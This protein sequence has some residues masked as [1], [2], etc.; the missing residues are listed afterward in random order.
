MRCFILNEKNLDYRYGIE[1]ILNYLNKLDIKRNM[2]L[3]Y[4]NDFYPGVL[5]IKPLGVDFEDT[6]Y[7]KEDFMVWKGFCFNSIGFRVDN[8][9]FNTEKK[10]LEA[11]K[12]NYSV[13][14]N[15]FH[16][17]SYFV[18]PYMEQINLDDLEE[19]EEEEVEAVKY[20]DKWYYDNGYIK[21]WGL[22]WI[23]RG[24]YFDKDGWNG[25]NTFIFIVCMAF[26]IF[27][28]INAIGGI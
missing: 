15:V 9:T 1:L 10:L 14:V 7:C 28:I 18:D 13:E 23:K 6:C 17:G 8:L 21:K 26:M 27:C 20:S 16:D 24:S 3:V 22:V 5:F 19:D 11:L 12:D 4:K 25:I 2:L